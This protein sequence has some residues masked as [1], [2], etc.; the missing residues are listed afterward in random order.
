[1]GA[2]VLFLKHT[3]V[4]FN[5]WVL[6][7]FYPFWPTKKVTIKVSLRLVFN[8]ETC[9]T[10]EKHLHCTSISVGFLTIYCMF[11]FTYSFKR[12]QYFNKSK[13]CV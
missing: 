3:H 5:S 2:D 9:Y 4:S 7:P 10:L 13:V 1:M 8:Q 6:S 12:N 11:C